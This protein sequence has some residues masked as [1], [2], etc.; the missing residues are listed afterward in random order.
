MESAA[1]LPTVVFA[2][3]LLLPE[4]GSVVVD[5]AVAVFESTVLM[6]TAGNT[7]TVIVKAALPTPIDAL[8][9][10]PVPPLPTA[11]VTQV[12]PAGADS[13]T[14]VVPAGTVS[15]SETEFAL[16]GPALVSVMV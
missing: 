16:L 3:K 5:D 6:G 8:E 10:E 11:G 1:G 4:T 14:K 9:Q 2:L 15:E 13:E 12:H 7:A